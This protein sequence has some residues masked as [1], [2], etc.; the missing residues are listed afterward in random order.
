MLE[1]WKKPHLFENKNNYLHLQ[2]NN[3]VADI[4]YIKE[5]YQRV[6]IYFLVYFHFILLLKFL[7]NLVLKN[8]RIKYPY[9]SLDGGNPR[10]GLC[11][12]AVKWKFL[13]ASKITHD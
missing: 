2:S 6:Y 5:S 10:M 4:L 7:G 1:T 13:L 11:S 8:K 3:A 12:K 9:L